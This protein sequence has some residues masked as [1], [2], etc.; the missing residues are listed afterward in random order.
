MN[1]GNSRERLEHELHM[2]RLEHEVH[3][4][5]LEH[6]AGYRDTQNI[7]RSGTKI[8]KKETLFFYY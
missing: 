8:E 7:Y 4:E 6:R 3:V 5:R 2:E 1:V